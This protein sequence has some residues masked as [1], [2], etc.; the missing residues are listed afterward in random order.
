MDEGE[1]SHG[2]VVRQRKDDQESGRLW[3]TTDY[4]VDEAITRSFAACPFPIAAR[5]WQGVFQARD[6]GSVRIESITPDR[7]EQAY[8]L[9]LRFR[10]KPRISFTDL[11]SFVVMRELGLSRVL[12]ADVHFSQVG[13]GFERIP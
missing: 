3:V 13:M 9:R 1:A 8:Q 7:F 11:T 2:A 10:D 12:T 6:A 5:V 4:I